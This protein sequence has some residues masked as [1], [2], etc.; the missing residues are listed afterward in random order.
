M[1]LVNDSYLF[2]ATAKSRRPGMLTRAI[3]DSTHSVG[4]NLEIQTFCEDVFVVEQISV[5]T[6]EEEQNYFTGQQEV[7]VRPN[8]SAILPPGVYRVID[9]SLYLIMCG[10]P[11]MLPAVRNVGIESGPG[12]LPRT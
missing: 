11:P 2:D 7:T 5:S 12:A 10:L 3:A 6:A 8:P 9:G 1:R 4:A